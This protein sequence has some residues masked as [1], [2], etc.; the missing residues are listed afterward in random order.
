MGT[1][2]FAGDILE[3]I[4]KFQ[5]V[6]CKL[7]VS[8]PDREVWRKK[9]LQKTAV[10]IVAENNNIEVLQPEKLRNNQ[11]FLDTLKS[12][13]LD[14]IVVVA[15]GK[16]IPKDILEIPKYRCI[17]IHGSILPKYRW[18]SPV[19]AAIKNGESETW[20]TIMYMSEGMDEWDMLKIGKINID[21]V[22]TSEDIFKKFVQIGPELLIQTLREIVS[23]DIEWF[24]QNES[25]ATYCWKITR[26]DGEVF[27]QEQSAQEI[28]DTYRA[29]TPWPWIFTSYEG[30]R[31][32]IEKCYVSAE[33]D[34]VENHSR[35]ITPGEFIQMDKKHFWIVTSDK[36]FLM[37]ESLKLEWKKS[38][39][40]MSFINGN[41]EIIWYKF[42]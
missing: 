2:A 27:F 29:Y 17:N 30:K 21:N 37:V 26:E 34:I 11:L 28:Y 16:I 19:Q 7:V 33:W 3:W 18:A 9:E 24:P 12:L 1:P 22:D 38:M 42:K 35:E 40:V 32:V 6:D 8:Q 20:L 31:L 25:E 15:Y 14:F 41:K 36:R 23:W 13:D 10:K 5:E 39:D 4:L